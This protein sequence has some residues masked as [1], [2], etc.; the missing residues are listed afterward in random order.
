MI[1]RNVV[2]SCICF[3]FFLFIFLIFT[4]KATIDSGFRITYLFELIF[5]VIFIT[6]EVAYFRYSNLTNGYIV[7]AALFECFAWGAV[8]SYIS[9]Y[10]GSI[11][12]NLNFE[13]L[14]DIMS[15]WKL[16]FPAAIF[17]FHLIAYFPAKSV[18]KK[19]NIN[20]GDTQKYSDGAKGGMYGLLGFV[21]G[22]G[23]LFIVS[24]CLKNSPLGL[25]VMVSIVICIAEF[26]LV[27]IVETLLLVCKKRC[28]ANNID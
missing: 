6:N 22:I 2:R 17:L 25:F 15:W 9:G 10:T 23:L 28:D 4:T 19:T 27:F 14:P 13:T 21:F 16:A 5:A 18:A 7:L 24:Y 20:K 26:L 8:D 3:D 1:R 12:E 11:K